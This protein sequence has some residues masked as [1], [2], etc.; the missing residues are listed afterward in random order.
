MTAMQVD[1]L[2]LR[3]SL[4]AALCDVARAAEIVGASQ[5]VCG[6]QNRA[7]RLSAD[8][9]IKDVADTLS[10]GLEKINRIDHLIVCCGP[11]PHGAAAS[12]MRPASLQRHEGPSRG[13]RIDRFFC[14]LQR[15]DELL[16]V[17]SLRHGKSKCRDRKISWS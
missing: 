13:L 5:V 12:C 11:H 15:R 10:T 16:M 7:L 3:L 9:S 6:R 14:E 8:V 1:L 4:Q 2:L 17:T